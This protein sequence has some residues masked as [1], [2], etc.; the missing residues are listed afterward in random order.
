LFDISRVFDVPI[1][2]FFEDMPEGMDATPISGP[3]GRM[4]GSTE[5]Q[6]PFSNREVDNFT[7]RETLELVRAY[8]RIPN[9]AIRK[10]MVDLMKSPA[11]AEFPLET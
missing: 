5:E 1:V 7:R 2:F 6:Q 9:R 10:Q 8:Y 11:P 3:L 4:Y